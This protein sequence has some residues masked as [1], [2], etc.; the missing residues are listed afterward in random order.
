M[1]NIQDR[2]LSSKPPYYF[3]PLFRYG[4]FQIIVLISSLQARHCFTEPHTVQQIKTAIQLPTWRTI[5]IG[6]Y[7][8]EIK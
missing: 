7:L 1:I 4:I 2:E 6:L 8:W 5:K 3:A